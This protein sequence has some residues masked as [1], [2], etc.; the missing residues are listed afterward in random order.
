VWWGEIR[1]EDHLI[2]VGEDGNV[3]AT[4]YLT[5]MSWKVVN[6]M[7]LAEDVDCY[8]YSSEPSGYINYGEIHDLLRSC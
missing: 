2:N 6:F 3:N 1:K 5:R 8:E 4:T 7:Y